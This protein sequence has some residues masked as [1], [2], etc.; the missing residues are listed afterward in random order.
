MLV[1]LATRELGYMYMKESST[2][3]ELEPKNKKATGAPSLD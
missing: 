2:L 3:E 1:A